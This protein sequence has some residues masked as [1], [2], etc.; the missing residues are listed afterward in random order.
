[1]K[2]NSKWLYFALGI[3]VFLLIGAKQFS[4]N[5]LILGDG[6][7]SDKSIT[8]KTDATDKPKLFWDDSDSKLKFTNDGVN[9][10]D[11]GSGSGSG[12]G[13]NDLSGS[14]PDCE[15]GTAGVPNGWTASGGTLSQ[16]ATAGELING[17]QSCEWDSD[18]SAQTLDTTAVA[19]SPRN[20]GNSCLGRFFYR[21]TGGSKAA[22]DF[23]VQAFDGTNPVNDPIDL[24]LSDSDE[25][26]SQATFAF[27]C[28]S[29]GSYRLRLTSAVSDAEAIV[30]DDAHL[31]QDDRVGEINGAIVGAG[32]DVAITE[33]NFT[34]A[35]GLTIAGTLSGQKIGDRL[36]L[37]LAA[38]FSGTGSSGSDLLFNIPSEFGSLT[39]PT[40]NY[41]TVTNRQDHGTVTSRYHNQLQIRSNGTAALGF[42]S[43]ATPTT[44]LNGNQFSDGGTDSDQIG[45]SVILPIN[46]WAG[47]GVSKTVTLQTQG[48]FVDA[49]VTGANSTSVHG[50][51]TYA[52]YFSSSWVMTLN[53]GSSPAEIG[54]SSTNPPTGQTCDTGSEQTSLA[55]TPKRLGA[56][57]VCFT[58][59]VNLAGDASGDIQQNY[60]QL[61]ETAIDSQTQ[62][63]M[64]KKTIGSYQQGSGITQAVVSLCDILNVTTINKKMVRFVTDVNI[65]NTPTSNILY[66]D[67]TENRQFGWTVIPLTQSFPQAVAISNVPSNSECSSQGSICSGAY[68]AAITEGANVDASTIAGGRWSRVGNEV[69]VQLRLTVDPDSG[70]TTEFNIS[71]PIASDFTDVEDAGGNVNLVPSSANGTPYKCEA[72][73]TTDDLR[74]LG[75]AQSTANSSGNLTFNYTVK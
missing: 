59:H 29:S 46:E 66:G 50:G 42:A 13:L 75:Y 70:T 47:K 36:H 6:T 63:G 4:E 54:C 72:D 19:V 39:V 30:I 37:T 45:F 15:A 56:H 51:Q 48:W 27:T 67:G 69:T 11:I 68:T 33:A 18:G 71:L 41:P 52:P 43:P 58:G 57:Y 53:P 26:V 1:M 9:S 61:W 3:T 23:T 8:F 35:D 20:Q 5:D 73:P 44:I 10:V 25:F 28:P 40:G 14:N 17:D 24:P 64:G 62:I 21:Y 49:T 31:G 7:A 12:G 60:Y 22:G 2:S 38:L 34:N 16:T 55:F 32:I 65:T 74:C